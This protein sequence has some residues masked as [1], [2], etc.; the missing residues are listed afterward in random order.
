MITISIRDYTT[1]QLKDLAY[2]L[3]MAQDEILSD[4]NANMTCFV[5][6]SAKAMRDAMIFLTHGV[7]YAKRLGA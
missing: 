6:E 2:G 7:I 1:E 5:A 4:T 3:S